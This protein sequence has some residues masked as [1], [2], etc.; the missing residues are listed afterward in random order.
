MVVVACRRSDNNGCCTIVVSEVMLM[1]DLSGSLA[2][3]G[4]IDLTHSIHLRLVCW[5]EIGRGI[6]ALAAHATRDHIFTG[7]EIA[8]VPPTPYTHKLNSLSTNLLW[9]LFMSLVSTVVRA[10]HSNERISVRHCVR[11][12]VSLLLLFYSGRR[13]SLASLSG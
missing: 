5:R 1:M 9:Q 13:A 3:G 8:N 12:A 11:I 6:F 2:C 7:L 4:V 10:S